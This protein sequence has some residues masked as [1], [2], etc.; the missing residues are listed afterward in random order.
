ML[1]IWTR[2]LALFVIGQICPLVY[3]FAFFVVEM[4]VKWH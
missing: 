4:L 2:P 1:K 3:D